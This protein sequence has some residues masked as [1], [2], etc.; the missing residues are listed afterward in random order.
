VY[1]SSGRFPGPRSMRNGSNARGWREGLPG[2]GRLG[3]CLLS[4]PA[5]LAG[6][7]RAAG[8]G[9]GCRGSP[10]CRRAPNFGPT[11][12]D[13]PRLSSS[14]VWAF[15]LMFEFVRIIEELVAV[16]LALLNAVTLL[17]AKA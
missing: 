17:A 12:R 11:L 10:R 1:L 4:V 2:R 15:C 7:R 16:V 8:G 14:A 13:N 9:E 6:Y 5:R 3:N